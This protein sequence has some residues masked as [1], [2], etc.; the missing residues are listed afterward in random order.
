MSDTEAI[1]ALLGRYAEALN[2]S[3]TEAVMKLY[4]EDG[5]FMPQHFASSVGADAVR[6][7]YDSV[8]RAIQLTVKFH[9]R[10]YNRFRQSG[11]LLAP[12]LRA[13]FL[14]TPQEKLVLRQIRSC[15][16]CARSRM[17][18]RLRDIAFQPQTHPAPN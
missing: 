15:S 5:V 2:N 13:P 8:F 18:G 3:D 4:T 9:L 14:Y 11:R 12:T 7:A 1:A 16:F 10:K 17:T 6:Q